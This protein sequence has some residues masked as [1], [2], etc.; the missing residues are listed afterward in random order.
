M[1][2]CGRQP[3]GAI[4][5]SSA[6]AGR[7]TA[8]RATPPSMRSH[9]K[10][11]VLM[12]SLAGCE[13]GVDVAITSS[14]GGSSGAPEDP[15]TSGSTCLG[16]SETGAPATTEAAG[17]SGSST[18]REVAST[19]RE[20]SGSES[21]T[22]DG[23]EAVLADDGWACLCDGFVSDMALCGCVEVDPGVCSC[24]ANPPFPD[25]APCKCITIGALCLCGSVPS[26]PESC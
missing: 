22:G 10:N 16:A 1:K 24:P 4:A 9:A 13:I 25:E 17:S 19:G 18:G 20:E 6:R 7:P 3:I 21:T 14:G 12:L 26:P 8:A 2:P 11:A 5:R 23:C 15:V